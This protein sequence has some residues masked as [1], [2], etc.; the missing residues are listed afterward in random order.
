MGAKKKRESSERSNEMCGL[1]RR[2]ENI[3]IKGSFGMCGQ[4]F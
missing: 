3:E 2:M 4:V 1:A